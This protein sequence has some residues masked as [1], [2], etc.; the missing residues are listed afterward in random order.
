MNLLV[1][2]ASFSMIGVSPPPLG[3]LYMAAMDPETRVWDSVYDGSPMQT[4]QHDKYRVV[5]VQVYTPGRKESLR[6]LEQAKANGSITVAG[7]PHVAVLRKQMEKYEF[8]DHL[9]L[10]DGEIAWRWICDY[11]SGRD[12]KDKP[13]R[14]IRRLVSN[15]DALPLPA[16]DRIPIQRHRH[17]ICVVLGRGCDGQCTFCSAWWVNGKYRFHG[18]EWITAHLKV[19][20][21]NGIRYLV[22][23]DDCLTNDPVGTQGL[24]NAM[25]RFHFTAEGVTRVDKLTRETVSDLKRVG[26][27]KLGFGIES[28]SQTI[29]DKINKKTDLSMAFHA[30]EWCREFGVQFKALVM[31]G[32]PFETAETRAEDAEFRRKL[33]PD[34]WGSVGYIMVFP[35]T[36]LY[37][38]LVHEGKIDDTFWDSE[39]P[40]YRLG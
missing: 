8:I 1:K 35:G 13:P 40:C 17:R 7:G 33:N 25:G 38:N 5:G 2:P 6:Y 34:E 29:L 27:T 37:R 14:V 28:G 30:R 24:I 4:I 39:E 36:Q 9:V 21:D 12:I 31:Q 23:D 22:W 16:W 19:L 11:Y 18:E 15:L 32:F 3:L 20:W 10:G 26:F